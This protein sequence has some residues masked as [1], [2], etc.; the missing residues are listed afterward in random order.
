[1]TKKA[2]LSNLLDLNATEIAEHV[3][4]WLREEKNWLVIIDNL[5]DINIVQ[6]FLKLS[7]INIH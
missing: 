2:G 1:M 4:L 7:R 6:G 3:L 5:D